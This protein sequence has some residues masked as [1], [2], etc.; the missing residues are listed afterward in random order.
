MGWSSYKM[1]SVSET[2]PREIL[3]RKWINVVKLGMI[4]YLILFLLAFTRDTDIE[5]QNQVTVFY[6]VALG[7]VLPIFTFFSWKLI[8]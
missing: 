6:K 7:V 4:E 3:S 2:G 1:D 8:K 5:I